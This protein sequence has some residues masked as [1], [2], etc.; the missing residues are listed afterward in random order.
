[1][2]PQETTPM[3]PKAAAEE[4]VKLWADK[5]LHLTNNIKRRAH[6]QHLERQI[7][8]TN[9]LLEIIDAKIDSLMPKQEAIND[10]LSF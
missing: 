6:I 8:A 3:T 2:D 9:G 1:M 4:L 10:L 7:E 5:N